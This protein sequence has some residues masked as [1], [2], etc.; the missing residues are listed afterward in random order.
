[1]QT[2]E[3]LGFLFQELEKKCEFKCFIEDYFEESLKS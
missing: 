2:T 3:F 1:M